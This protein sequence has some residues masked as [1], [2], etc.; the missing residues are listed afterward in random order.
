MSGD[1]DLAAPEQESVAC[2]VMRGGTSKALFFHERDVPPAGPARDAM[3]KRAIGTPDPLQIDGLGG[4]RLVTSKLAIVAASARADADVDYTFAQADIE[5]DLIGYTGNCGNIAAAVGPFAIDE[6]LVAAVEPVT[7]VRIFNTNTATRVVAQVHVVG[8][9]ARVAGDCRIDG[10]PGT[11][12]EIRMDYSDAVGAA[13]GQLLPTGHAIDTLVL[14]D[15][16]GVEV[17]I[18][19]VANVC[20]FIA[21]PDVGLGGRESPDEISANAVAICLIGEIQS[22]AGQL[23]G[24]WPDWR[25]QSRPGLPLAVLVAPGTSPDADVQCRLVFLGRCH[26]S[27]AGTASVCTAAASR[28]AGTLVRRA[29][30]TSALQRP[31]LRLG[32]PLGLME[33][34]V[35]ADAP[36]LARDTRFGALSLSRTARR[37]ME[38]R[39]LLPDSPH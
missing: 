7:T 30:E 26:D 4:A 17:S 10:V 23:I 39:V 18:C 2:V 16:R 33:V 11:G 19:D 36:A 6:G 21:A 9:K 1:D 12:A 13:S 32:H 25:A 22:R 24:L 29:I 5:R 27:M 28:I 37:L 20:V 15:G 14:D 34:R 8:G 38:G 35:E 3:L 31:S